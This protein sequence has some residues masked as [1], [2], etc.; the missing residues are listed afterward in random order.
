MTMDLSAVLLLGDAQY[1]DGRAQAWSVFDSTWGRLKP[2]I[3]PVP[4]NHEFEN[5]GAQ[6]YYDY[7][8][9][10]G[11]ANGPAGARNWG[12]YSFD[13]GS[14]HVI[15][16]NSQCSASPA[17]TSGVDCSAGSPQETWLR[18]D[19]AAHPTQCTIAYWHHPLRSSG[20]EAEN[21]AM[22]P[23]WQALYEAGVDV[24]L[25][26][27]DHAYERLAPQDPFGVRDGARGIRAFVVGTGGKSLQGIRSVAA[28]S[29]VRKSEFGVL[30]MTLG[31]DSYS[32]KFVKETG[33]TS[34]SGAN[35]CH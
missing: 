25:N 28:Y 1:N 30:E 17:K 24:V 9:G 22:L 3:H 27:H 13:I 6:T 16:L 5:P 35:S 26:G 15:A 19:L 29:E 18:Q 2:L 7:F 20:F 11:A 34:D 12:A 10:V 33:A 31:P 14:W 21:T 8:N 32:W 4:G 23:I